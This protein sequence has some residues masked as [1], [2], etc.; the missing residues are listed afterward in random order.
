MTREIQI[1]CLNNG[2]TI[3]C[4][5][6]ITLTQVAEKLNVQLAHPI[7]G[8]LVN[9]SLRETS[10]E[11]FHSKTIRFIDITHPDGMRMYV[12]SLSFVLLAAVN[13]LFPGVKLRIEHSV[14]KGI[15]C[16]LESNYLELTVQMV[17][18]LADKMRQIIEE[19]LPIEQR[20][21]ETEEVIALFEGLG[22]IDKS[23]LIRHR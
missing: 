20:A 7:L 23:E 8:A 19:T 13:E 9:N 12:R 18:D 2:K 21:D 5:R 14:S 11:V 6:G 10:Y 1:K 3:T 16:E 4:P 17:I 15:Y 22:L